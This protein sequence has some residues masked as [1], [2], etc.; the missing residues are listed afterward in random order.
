MTATLN[1]KPLLATYCDDGDGAILDD[2][3]DAADEPDNDDAAT[4]AG[5]D[6]EAE[7]A[8]MRQAC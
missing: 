7:D 3:D 6:V 1:A 2:D 5:H 4:T 8:M